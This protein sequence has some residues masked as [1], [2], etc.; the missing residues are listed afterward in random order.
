MNYYRELSPNANYSNT[1]QVSFD[2]RNT[3]SAKEKQYEE[4]LQY[5]IQKIKPNLNKNLNKKR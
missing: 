1:Y 2:S 3:A 5:I 4:P